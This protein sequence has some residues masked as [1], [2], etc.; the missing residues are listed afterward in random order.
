MTLF[1]STKQTAE[2]LGVSPSTLKAWRLG[3]RK[4]PPRLVEGAH[5]VSLGERK[6]LYHRELMLDFLANQHRPKVHQK[7]VTAYLASL[8]SSKAAK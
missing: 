2:I 1:L 3:T 5:W 6:V 7:A 8:P 4:Q